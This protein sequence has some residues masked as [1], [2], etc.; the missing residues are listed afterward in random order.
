MPIMQFRLTYV[1]RPVNC[2][3]MSRLARINYTSTIL[4]TNKVYRYFW[5]LVF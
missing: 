5:S 1:Q 2:H 3:T 4:V